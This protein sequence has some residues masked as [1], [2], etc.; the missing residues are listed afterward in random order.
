[1]E[2]SITLKLEEIVGKENVNA[3]ERFAKMVTDFTSILT[4]MNFHENHTLQ[5]NNQIVT[6]QDSCHLRNVMRVKE[7]PR[8]LIQS[9]EN[10]TYQELPRA[11][12]CCGSA[13]IYNILQPDMSMQILDH[14]MEDVKGTN[15]HT[16]VTTNPG[17]LIQMKLG[18]QRDGLENTVGAVHLADL[19]MEALASGLEVNSEL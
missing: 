16:V 2:S 18:I 11:D 19:L 3:S 10:V 4:D 7:A 15:A 13:G 5:V 17:C 9:I 6:Y 12:Q 8:L 14:K 1:M